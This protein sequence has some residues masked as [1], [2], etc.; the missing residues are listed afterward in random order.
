MHVSRFLIGVVGVLAALFGGARVAPGEIILFWSTSGITNTNFRY[1]TALTNFLPHFVPPTPVTEL[2]AGTYDLFLWGLFIETPTMPAGSHIY[3]LNLK[4]EGDA[5]VV[6][7][8]A[9]RQNKT[10]AGAYRRWD[11][12]VGLVLD[13]SVAAIT[14]RGIEFLLPPDFNNDLYY[15][16]TQQFLFGAARVTGAVG[17][18]KTVAL[19]IESL[20]G[21]IAMRWGMIDLPDPPVFS[22]VVTFVPEPAAGAALVLTALLLRRR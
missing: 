10:G 21:G 22:A 4:F 19:E 18:Q 7:S 2:T 5:A 20:S 14:A 17:Q 11:G 13:D 3:G 1:S 6:Q 8:V 15:P 9:Y 16:A 12:S